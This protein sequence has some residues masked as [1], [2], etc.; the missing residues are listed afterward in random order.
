MSSLVGQQFE[1]VVGA[2]AHGGFCVAR[3]EGRAIFVRH[4]LPGEKVIVEITEGDVDSRYL[5][6]DAV[7][8]VQA[9]PD[10]VDSRC[11]VAGPGGCGGCDWQHV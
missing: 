4:S 9:S 1:V 2:V 8:V 6:A 3:H 7:K 11:S 10:R 5:R